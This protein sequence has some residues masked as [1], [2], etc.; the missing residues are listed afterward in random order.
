MSTILAV[1]VLLSSIRVATARPT[2][3]EPFRTAREWAIYE[4]DNRT[5]DA[6]SRTF[7]GTVNVMAVKSLFFCTSE[8]VRSSALLR[9]IQGSLRAVKIREIARY[10]CG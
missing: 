10:W 3:Q 1:T 8:A 5:C 4:Q 6:G 9:Q 7:A 2:A